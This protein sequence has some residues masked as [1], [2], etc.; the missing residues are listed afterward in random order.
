MSAALP[1]RCRILPYELATGPANMARDEALLDSVAEGP[2]SAVLRTYGW[3]EPTLSLGYFQRIAEAEREPRWRGV[4]MVRRPSGGGAIWHHH[5]VTYALVL[6]AQHPLARRS[7][8]LYRAVHAAI[9]QAIA[10]TGIAAERRGVARADSQQQRPFL[11]F[12]D[13]DPEDL[14]VR[15]SKIVGSAQRRRRGAVLQHG[16]LLLARSPMTPELPGLTDLG[17]A[18]PAG[19]EWSARLAAALPTALGLLAGD[20]CLTDQERAQAEKLERDVYRNSAWTS[21]R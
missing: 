7:A 11:C 21:K 19:A 14:L 8:E 13:R 10:G 20:D 2:R 5:E 6:P 9:A 1:L 16:A 18:A 15:G 17:S 3:V 12:A 4:P